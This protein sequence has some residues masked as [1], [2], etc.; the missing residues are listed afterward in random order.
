VTGTLPTDFSYTGQR[1]QGII[2]LYDYH[3]R[4]YD[5]SLGRFIQAD[6]IVPNPGNPRDLNRYTYARNNVLKYVDPSGHDCL[7]I[8]D[9]EYCSDN[10]PDHHSV[11]SI[12][13]WSWDLLSEEE[14]LLAYESYLRFRENPDY[15]RSL[16]GTDTTELTYL[17]EWA[18]YAENLPLERLLIVDPV[19]NAMDRLDA[20]E[21]RFFRGEISDAEFG[22]LKIPLLFALFAAEIP[23][24]QGDG[25]SLAVRRAANAIDD[26]LGPNSKFIVNKHGDIVIVSAGGNRRFRIDWNYTH[27]HDNVHM[28]VEWN[29]GG[30]WVKK[31]IYPL[32][33]E[34][35]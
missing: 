23:D 7:I 5:P 30:K 17:Q 18:E 11:P 28:H 9:D 24:A 1:E 31:P 21:Q 29:E 16:Y 20:L 34:P 13:S 33:V 15:Y 6:T 2:R 19:S 8:D 32:D 4:F 35:K 22:K 14:Q 3:A 26:W 10:L 25:G 12:D 27:P